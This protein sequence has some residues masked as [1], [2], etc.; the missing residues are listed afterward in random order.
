MFYY[1]R[2]RLSCRDE[3][4]SL[5]LQVWFGCVFDMRDQK[6]CSTLWILLA[7]ISSVSRD[8]FKEKENTNELLCFFSLVNCENGSSPPDK[9][10]RLKRRWVITL[11]SADRLT[12]KITALLQAVVFTVEAEV[13]RKKDFM[14]VECFHCWTRGLPKEIRRSQPHIHCCCC[15][16]AEKMGFYSWPELKWQNSK[17]S[18]FTIYIQKH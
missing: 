7:C 1:G 11:N 2:M 17:Y 13:K 6:M 4:V 12:H 5:T 18:H 10:T 14:F 16:P 8:Q 15:R 3:S 9:P